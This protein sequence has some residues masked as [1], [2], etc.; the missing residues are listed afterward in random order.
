[1]V[2]E[3][4]Q[5]VEIQ[6]SLYKQL[7]LSSFTLMANISYKT[8]RK[9]TYALCSDRWSH[10]SSTGSNPSLATGDFILPADQFDEFAST[11]KL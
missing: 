3:N 11:M 5:M 9:H 2:C 7:L 1:M 10:S 6:K 8:R 4:E